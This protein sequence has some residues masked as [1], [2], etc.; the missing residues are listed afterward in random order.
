MEAAL[1]NTVLNCKTT[2]GAATFYGIR[3]SF[4]LD[5]LL[6]FGNEVVGPTYFRPNLFQ[7]QLISGPTQLASARISYNNNP[8][9]PKL[10]WKRK[11]DNTYYNPLD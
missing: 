7:A 10:E 5:V 6:S 3:G 11:P 9:L 1:N 2:L 8:I 4:L